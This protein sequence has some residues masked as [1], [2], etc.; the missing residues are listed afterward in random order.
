MNI[1]SGW[2]TSEFWVTLIA[3]LAIILSVTGVVPG[4]TGEAIQEIGPEIATGAFALITNVF[5]IWSRVKAK[6]NK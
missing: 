5:Y 2:K 4:E 3:N 6:E 1:K